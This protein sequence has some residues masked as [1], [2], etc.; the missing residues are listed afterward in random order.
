MELADYV[1]YELMQSAFVQNGGLLYTLIIMVNFWFLKH[2][3]NNII[4]KVFQNFFYK[5]VIKEN[6][7]MFPIISKHLERE[8]G[9]RFRNVLLSSQEKIIDSW[10]YDWKTQDR[11]LAEAKMRFLP[12]DGYVI[13]KKNDML[14]KM[15]VEKEEVKGSKDIFNNEMIVFNLTGYGWKPKDKLKRMIKL[16]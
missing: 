8:Y 16:F 7:T 11:N 4:N 10:Q 14:I 9:D 13:F 6:T 1:M 5:I 3:I 12:Y 15:E 2:N